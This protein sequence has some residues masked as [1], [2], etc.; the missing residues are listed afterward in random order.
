M[1]LSN[2]AIYEALDLGRIVLDPEPGPRYLQ[3]GQES[4]YDTHS[5]DVRLAKYLSIPRAGPYTFDL[6]QPGHQKFELAKFLAANSDQVE[7]PAEGYPL[8]PHRFVLGLTMERLSLPID[9]PA[10]R[11]TLPRRRSTRV[12]TGRSP[13]K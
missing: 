11:F 2:V 3:V 5:V 7:I 8:E 6:Y 1:S 12:S 13:W 9:I 10:C 4:P